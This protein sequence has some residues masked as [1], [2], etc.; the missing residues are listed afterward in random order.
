[1]GAGG[2]PVLQAALWGLWLWGAGVVALVAV[3]GSGALSS[4]WPVA[5]VDSFVA[6]GAALLGALLALL[7]VF[8]VLLLFVSLDECVKTHIGC[9]HFQNTTKYL[10]PRLKIFISI[11]IKT[12]PAPQYSPQQAPTPSVSAFPLS[13]YHSF[14]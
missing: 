9:L 14:C 5:F 13:P 3:A 12:P 11:R 2:Q 4:W 10:F 1:V 6:G 8:L 7:L